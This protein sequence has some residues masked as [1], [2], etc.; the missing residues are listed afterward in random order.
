MTKHLVDIDDDALRQAQ[1]ELRTTTI[2]DT[3]NEALM[4]AAEVRRKRVERAIDYFAKAD[5][6]SRFDRAELWRSDT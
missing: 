1:A 2:K 4:R 6:M 5:L 3:V